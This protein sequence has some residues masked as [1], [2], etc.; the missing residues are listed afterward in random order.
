[1]ELNCT[2]GPRTN[3]K[4]GGAVAKKLYMSGQKRLLGLEMSL[5]RLKTLAALISI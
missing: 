5:R 4:E 2:G 1:M 3:N